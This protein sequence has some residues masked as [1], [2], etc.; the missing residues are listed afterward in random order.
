[1]KK[2]YAIALAIIAAILTANLILIL[3]NDIA[4][5]SQLAQYWLE[6]KR[7][8][9][10][11]F[12]T[13]PPL[14]IWFYTLPAWLHNH[15]PGYYKLWLVGYL[16]VV[17]TGLWW[18]N[19]KQMSRLDWGGKRYYL[20]M[21]YALTII[22]FV[23]PV[24]SLGKRDVLAWLSMLPL[25]WLLD[26][27]L[28]NRTIPSLQIIMIALV[29]GLGMVLKPYFLLP[30]AAMEL[31]FMV[32]KGRWLAWL[33]LELVILFF[34]GVIYILAVAYLAPHYFGDILPI[35]WLIY[36]KVEQLSIIDRLF[37]VVSLCWY[38]LTFS[39]CVSRRVI[40]WPAFVWL[41]WANAS[42]FWLSFMLQGQ[43]WFYHVYPGL[44][45]SCLCA[46]FCLAWVVNNQFRL[47]LTK[48]IVLGLPLLAILI[49]AFQDYFVSSLA[50]QIGK[51]YDAHSIRNQIN[52]Q[53]Q[54][55]IKPN[56]HALLLLPYV[57]NVT[58]IHFERHM[59]YWL[60][61]SLLLLLPPVMNEL[62]QPGLS[63]HKQQTL[64]NLKQLIDN[65]II[66]AL[67]KQPAMVVLP[68]IDLDRRYYKISV[69]RNYKNNRH[70]MNRLE[71]NYKPV[72]TG[73]HLLFLKRVDLLS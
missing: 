43:G 56:Q 36:G 11:F 42:G 10:D 70:I 38:L 72:H 35:V 26:Q 63:P 33:R 13:N 23:L 5:L 73:N 7:Y 59:D 34:V 41:L 8:F 31:C 30:I 48:I 16:F 53:L 29:A 71:H 20:L 51:Q 4:W 1:M 40:K 49:L 46:V 37:L 58:N 62:Q 6:G 55:H 57:N 39:L 2:H 3:D 18:I 17:T 15:L 14:I 67:Q 60:S 50:Y 68:S 65:E 28:N 44:A 19:L 52:T 61:P 22:V 69:L 21:L 9:V 32:L 12:E 25:V 24:D 54:K 47:T 45:S 64:V 27:R 66:K